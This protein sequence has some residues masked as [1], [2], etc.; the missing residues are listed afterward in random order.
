MHNLTTIRP[1][2]G[3]ADSWRSTLHGALITYRDPP[4]LQVLR[5]QTDNIEHSL[6]V[7]GSMARELYKQNRRRTPKR[8]KAMM[9][10]VVGGAFCSFF[11]ENVEDELVVAVITETML[12]KEGMSVARRNEV[13]EEILERLIVKMKAYLSSR[14]EV[15]L[16]SIVARL[17]DPAVALAWTFQEN[18]CQVF[19]DN[20]I[21]RDIFGALL[22]RTDLER[23][24][25]ATLPAAPPPHL[26]PLYLMSF[27][28][29]PGAYVKEKVRSKF[30]VPNGLT[31]EYLLKFRYG[32][33]DE[34]DIMDS[35][36]E[37]W[38]DWGAF[39]D[40]PI[41][42]YQDLFPWD[43]TE[44]YNRYPVKCGNCNISKHVW[45][46]PFDSWSMLTHH[47]ARPRQLYPRPAEREVT[48]TGPSTG[49]MS[50][51]SWFQNRMTV[52][53]AQDVLLTAAV[54][55][56]RCEAFQE[57]THWLHNQSD[58]K[59]D[60]LKLGGIQRAQPFSHHFE[61]G[62]YHLYF[63]AEWTH[64]AQPLKIAAYERIR[65]GRARQKD[66]GN[67]S[68]DDD[69]G[70]G[71]GGFGCGTVFAACAAAC[72]AGCGGQCGSGCVSS[73]DSGGDGGGCSGGCGG[74]CGG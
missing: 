9:K 44:A 27:V 33:H 30:D 46:F 13:L 32:R 8:Y 14:I 60:R 21:N 42:S 1:V 24:D 52:L 19:C 17:I 57:S 22:P 63:A 56:A 59:R 58:V 61:K 73:C 28:C 54:A 55:M 38:T 2:Q 16:A 18:N 6:L 64:L 23:A 71:C 67:P 40:G 39:E 72:A 69:R 70:G 66:V 5:D 15:Y 49:I 31:E 20:L 48:G 37:Y 35:L 10:Q 51:A 50:D 26:M 62:A 45:A 29:R 12:L 53:L 43:C 65:D 68:T 47:L 4:N 11:D 41:Y 3:F 25:E 74:G 36:A 34:S 7:T